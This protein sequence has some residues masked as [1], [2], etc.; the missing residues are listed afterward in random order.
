MGLARGRITAPGRLLHQEHL[1][2]RDN[3]HDLT[4][5]NILPAGKS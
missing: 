3:A 2:G 4:S 1:Y 5:R